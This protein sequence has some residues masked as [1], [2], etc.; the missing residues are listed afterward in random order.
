MGLGFQAAAAL[1]L[2][3]FRSDVGRLFVDDDRV[4]ERVACLVPIA[5]C[6]MVPDGFLGSV[7]GVLRCVLG[8]ASTQ[9]LAPP[10]ICCRRH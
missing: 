9:Q 4:V 7:Q 2:L 5:T 3:L 1:G 10:D 6:Y 8:P